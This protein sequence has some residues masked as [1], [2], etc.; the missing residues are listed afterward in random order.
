MKKLTTKQILTIEDALYAEIY[1]CE[2]K[3]D[4]DGDY[5]FLS[6]K[7]VGLEEAMNIIGK[8]K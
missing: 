3:I 4:N 6:A 7:I 5:Y 1:K 8:I 2:E